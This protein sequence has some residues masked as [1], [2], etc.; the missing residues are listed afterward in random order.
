MNLFHGTLVGLIG[1]G[2]AQTAQAQISS[3]TLTAFNQA[4]ETGDASAIEV[5]STNLMNEAI[6]NPDDPDALIAAYEAALKLCDIDCEAAL[7]GAEFALGFPATGQHPIMAER[8]LLA[9]FADFSRRSTGATRARLETALTN[10]Q[11]PTL[12]SARAFLPLY[13]DLA[14]RNH[15]QP[16][17]RVARIAVEH[18]EPV[19]SSVL[20]YYL[21][22]LEAYGTTLFLEEKTVASHEALVRWNAELRRLRSEVTLSD[23][24]D[25]L[26]ATYWRSEAWVLAADTYYRSADDESPVETRIRADEAEHLSE[27]QVDAIYA[28]YD[29]PDDYDTFANDGDATDFL[30]RCDIE[31]NFLPR[32]EFPRRAANLGVI[33]TVFL[34]IDID[35]EGA[36]VDARLLASVP[37]N[38]FDQQV[39]ET[40]SQWQFTVAEDEDPTSCRLEQS[41]LVYPISFGFGRP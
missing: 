9:A 27:E 19:R 30:P 25:W 20:Q 40:I 4:V 8:E 31:T 37:P 33:G 39:V 16:S 26:E 34:E 35:S 29:I 17:A 15:F 22:A 11:D 28:E 24:P 21:H 41:N 14:G 38:L 12:L 32:L 36:V 6:A 7:P 1:L 13:T 5:A 3:N 18:L 23:A 10:M 2:L